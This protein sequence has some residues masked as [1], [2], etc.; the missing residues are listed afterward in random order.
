M[1]EDDMRTFHVTIKTWD[2][3]EE[4]DIVNRIYGAIL[5]LP[6]W[7]KSCEIAEDGRPFKFRFEIEGGI[8]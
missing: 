1:S 5:K 8:E 4:L 2:E 6:I 3:A 7:I